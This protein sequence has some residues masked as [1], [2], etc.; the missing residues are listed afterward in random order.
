MS[1]SLSIVV[2]LY[3]F[4]WAPVFVCVC[5]QW[6]GQT[7]WLLEEHNCLVTLPAWLNH[8]PGSGGGRGGRLAA[9]LVCSW[10]R[11]PYGCYADGYFLRAARAGYCKTRDK[12]GYQYLKYSL[13]KLEKSED[14][15][16]GNI[17]PAEK[18][19][20][21]LFLYLMF[22]SPGWEFIKDIK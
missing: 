21:D 11:C 19:R 17:N 4:H 20:K 1:S 14:G 6:C 18:G 10:G 22:T 8:K 15:M 16:K 9:Y 7:D 5:V 3:N 12:T 2:V 13:Y